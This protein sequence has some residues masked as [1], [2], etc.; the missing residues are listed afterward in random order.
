[1][2]SQYPCRECYGKAEW[3][4][5]RKRWVEVYRV[6]HSMDDVNDVERM[7]GVKLYMEGGGETVVND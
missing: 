7:S 1:V 6:G 3:E 5:L 2:T 4:E